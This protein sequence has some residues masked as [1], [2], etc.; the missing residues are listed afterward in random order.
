[1]FADRVVEETIVTGASE[2]ILAPD[3]LQVIGDDHRKSMAYSVRKDRLDDEDRAPT[4]EELATLRKVA[5]TMP[6]TAYMICFL[7]FA[8]KSSLFFNMS[9]LWTSFG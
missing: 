4:E 7:E 5:T 3:Q 9:A 2:G 6:V 8:G 1:M